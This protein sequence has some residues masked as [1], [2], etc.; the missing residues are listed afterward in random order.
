MLSLCIRSAHLQ[1][2]CSMPPQNMPSVIFTFIPIHP[3]C[4]NQLTNTI[5][6][7]FKFFSFLFKNPLLHYSQILDQPI[8]FLCFCS[9]L[10]RNVRENEVPVFKG[11]VIKILFQ[12]SV[13]GLNIH[14]NI[15]TNF[16]LLPFLMLHASCPKSTSFSRPPILHQLILLL[17]ELGFLTLKKI[18]LS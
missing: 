11:Y 16:K 18:F 3:W 7:I 12:T 1:S 13:S 4:H 15:F 14:S 6:S 5:Y 8:C 2:S 17:E 10:L 9:Q